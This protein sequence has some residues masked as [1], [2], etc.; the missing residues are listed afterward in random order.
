MPRSTQPETT[1]KVC[2]HN[3]VVSKIHPG[4][5]PNSR[6]TH[7]AFSEGRQVAQGSLTTEGG[8]LVET[9]FN[10]SAYPSLS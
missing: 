5:F 1:S 9:R 10:H 4:I 7:Q 3:L 6:T 8:L 2:G